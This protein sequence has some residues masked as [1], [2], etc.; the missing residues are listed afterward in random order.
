MP[1][2][3][4][5]VAAALLAAAALVVPERSLS[6]PEMEARAGLAR[7]RCREGQYDDALRIYAELLAATRGAPFVRVGLAAALFEKGDYRG[8]EEQY[9]LLLV[10]EPE[11]PIA[12]YDLAQTLLK[13]SRSVEA[14]EYLRRFSVRYGT[15]LTNLCTPAG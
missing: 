10:D 2:R 9:R 7:L 6:V 8:A 4:F 5:A 11:S 15:V 14:G 3:I 13:Q 12:L 1:K